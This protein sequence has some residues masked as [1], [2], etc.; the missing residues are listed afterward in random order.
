MGRNLAD[1]I[2][3]DRSYIIHMG[4]RQMLRANCD[5]QDPG[6]LVYSAR[7]LDVHMRGAYHIAPPLRIKSR[8]GADDAHP[9]SQG[10]AI[11]RPYG[12]IFGRNRLIA[13]LPTAIWGR[14]QISPPPLFGRRG[15]FQFCQPKTH[16]KSLFLVALVRPYLPFW[17]RIPV[18][19]IGN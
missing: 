19:G 18:M 12:A 13:A 11:T 16:A 10:G 17:F 7:A 4:R 15:V 1:G 5:A 6:A 14:A 9:H 2:Q 8:Y 3:E